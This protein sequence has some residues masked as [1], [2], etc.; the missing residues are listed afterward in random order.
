MSSRSEVASPSPT[1]RSAE[2]PGAALPAGAPGLPTWFIAAL[3]LGAVLRL[4]LLSATPGTFDVDVWKI[5]TLALEKKG[6]IAYY[7][8]GA[9]Q[10]N[11]PPPI[12][13]FMSLVADFSNASGIPFAACL[14]FPFALLD[15]VTVVL[16]LRWLHDWPNR[17]VIAAAFW[18]HP[19]AILYSSHHGNTDSAIATFAVAGAMFASRGNGAWAGAMLGLGVWIKLPIVLAGPAL[20][21]VLGNPRE[22]LRFCAV[23]GAVALAG[24]A[25]SLLL[26][27]RAVIDAVLLYPGLEIRTSSGI[28][29]WGLLNLLPDLDSLSSSGRLALL[30]LRAFV[31]EWNSVIAIGPVFLIAWLN[32]GKQ[33]A[34]AT[35]LGL[36][37]AASFTL[38]YGFTAF[39]AFQYFA[40][41]I[42]F[43]LL[44]PRWFSLGASLIATA[45]VYGAYAWLCGGPFLLGA[46]DFVGK[47]DWPATLVL[48][49]DIAN[50]FF[51][52][53]GVAF[54]AL[55]IRERLAAR[56][57][58][59]PSA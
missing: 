31:K 44:A 7:L 10:F 36:T 45:Y 54:I 39:W 42:P 59:E 26:D 15:G 24:Y 25:P 46:W 9:L 41:S 23:G 53:S 32:R 17:L 6:L 2:N 1:S 49:R 21:L 34:T 11:H 28:T 18:L 50:L 29:T 3:V 48:A 13:A 22:V 35:R 52:G 14:R 16:L 47:P 19:L 38:F 57:A 56:R 40:W 58:A 4:F 55:A 30:D 12:A 33:N 20:L 51:A 27:A 37:L 43:W 5:H 8:G